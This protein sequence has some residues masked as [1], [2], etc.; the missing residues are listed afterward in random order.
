MIENI[1]DLLMAWVDAITYLFNIVV[2]L[3]SSY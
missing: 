2:N 1:L 3:I